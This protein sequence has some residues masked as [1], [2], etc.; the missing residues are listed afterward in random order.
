MDVDGTVRSLLAGG[1]ADGASTAAIEAHGPAILGYV[2][3]L[4]GD[5]D[6]P[7][8]FSMFAEDL[9][10]G[11]PAFRWE[12]TLRAWAYRLAYHAAARFRRDP[13][14]RRAQRLPSSAASRLAASIAASGMSPGSRRD[15]LRRLRETLDAEDQTLLVLRVD[16]EMEW[17]EIAA[18]L[19][20]E[21]AERA[22]R[23]VT[24]AGLRKRFERLKDR[25]AELAR[26]QGLID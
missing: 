12:C 9:W 7:D 8:V 4:V 18:V 17:E 14:R 22:G 1:D 16:K 11:L 13:Y 21:G 15:R 25:L 20:G 26:A 19:G 10:R 6:G 2:C 24:S 5:D 3:T 23:Q